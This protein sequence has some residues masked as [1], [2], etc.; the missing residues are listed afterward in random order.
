MPER[1]NKSLMA[2]LTSG[3]LIKFVSLVGECVCVCLPACVYA[4]L[5]CT[6]V[7]RAYTLTYTHT[8]SDGRACVYNAIALTPCACVC[9]CAASFLYV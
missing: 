9:M 3:Y 2:I 1:Q 6:L 8:H 4:G 5:W 7:P